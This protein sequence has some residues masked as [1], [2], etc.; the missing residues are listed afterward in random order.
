MITID[1][2]HNLALLVA[3]SVVSGSVGQRWEGR[4]RVAVLQGAVFGGAAVV[5]MLEPYVLAPGVQFDA[6]SVAISISGLYFGPVAALVAGGM[7]GVCR[8][9]LGGA[10]AG[11]G[12]LVIAA[13][14]LPAVIAHYRW[15]AL[16]GN[17]SAARLLGLGVVTHA[18]MLLLM[19]SLPGGLVWEVLPNIGVPVIVLYPLATVFIG[20][21]LS[22][23]C[24]RRDSVRQLRENKERFRA[25]LYSIGDGVI[26]TD[27]QGRVREMNPVAERLS[28]WSED[29]ARGRPLE[30]A[31]RLVNEDSRAAV[32]NPVRRVL[33]GGQCVGLANHT[34]LVARDGTERPIADSGAPIYAEDGK[35]CGAVL[36]FRD[37]SEE[38]ETERALRG[39]R[40]RFERALAHIPD[41]IVIYDL[42]LRIQYINEATRNITGQPAS[43]FLGRRD[44]DVWSPAICD[45]FVP[46]LRAAL[47][48]RTVHTVETDLDLPGV[49][50][51]SLFITCVPVL[52]AAGEVLEILGITRDLTERKRSEAAL[53]ESE[54]LLRIAGEVAHIGGWAVD[55]PEGRLTWSDEVRAIH[56]EPPGFVPALAEAFEYFPPKWR[57]PLSRAFSACREA[58][59]PYDMELE[60]ITAGGRRLWARSIGQ[61]VRDNTGAIVRVQGA[62]QDITDIKQFESSL[63]QSQARFR[64]LADAMPLVV[65]TASPDGNVDYSSQTLARYTGR[66]GD[67]ASNER[68][69]EVLHPEDIERTMDVWTQAVQRGAHYVN[70]FRIL[71]RD[72]SYRWNHVEATPIRDEVGAIVKWY[73][74]ATDIHDTK[75]NEEAMTRMARRLTTTLESITD[76]FCILDNE[77]RYTYVNPEAERLARRPREELLGKRYSDFY[78]EIR[79]SELEKNLQCALREKRAISFEFYYEPFDLWLELHAYP[80]EEGLAISYRDITERVRSEHALRDVTRRLQGI[81][82]FSPLLIAELDLH[83]RYLV[84][85]RVHRELMGVEVEGKTLQ[86]LLPPAEA[87]LYLREI[88]AVVESR[89]ARSVEVIIEFRGAPHCFDTVLFPLTDG[90]GAVTSVGGIAIDVTDRKNA[91]DERERLESQLR[92]SQKMEAVGRLAGGVAHDFN[93]MLGVILGYTEMALTRLENDDELRSDLLQV[94]QAANRSADLTRQLLAFARKQTIA[95]KVLDLN[96]TVASILKMLRRL[97]GED[98]GLLWKPGGNLWPVCIDPTQVDQIL[99]NLTVNA[100]DAIRGVGKVTIETDCVAFDEAYCE[101]HPGFIPGEYV[102][103]AVSDDGC[104]MDEE[105]RTHVFEPFFT[106]KPQGQG[107]GLG[108]ATVYGIVK[109]NEGFIYVYS[110]PGRGTA[111]RVY[112]PRFEAPP[113]FRQVKRENARVPTGTETVLLVEDETALLMLGARQL[114][115]LGYTVLAAASPTEALRIAGTFDGEIDLL[116]TDVIMP[117]M[118]GRELWRQLDVLRPGIKTLFMSGYSADVIAHHGALDTGVHF[119]QKPFKVGS[120]AA[121]VR[122]ALGDTAAQ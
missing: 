35:T 107:T 116:I 39:G 18:I 8:I 85:N 97:I 28:G 109:Q 76:A 83:G 86:D 100:R 58:G 99:A 5:S 91:A 52:D 43:F 4:R 1:L 31:F 55:F 117:E 48:T 45:L 15:R 47:E 29:E 59:T 74:T 14:A 119:L 113:G 24:A 89:A 30:E 62:F 51:R 108:L 50:V 16:R 82:D 27:A 105:T 23:Q 81:L 84:A 90:Q 13:S 61:A 22:G 122:E 66:P 34:L 21:I 33:Q 10:G 78:P 41:V 120:M 42:D 75:Q 32:E 2:I 96:D 111:I 93:N 63:A 73:G 115:R 37:R 87:A 3:L 110:E 79:G 40:E 38:R 20:T 69:L 121:K 6:R 12:L 57:G 11:T 95:P 56:E 72:G 53:R 71:S 94:Q 26:T 25:T 106:T 54:A 88:A 77:F 98:V 70:E 9:L 104:G 64:Q 102:L 114:E 17:F 118:D 36:V 60:I 19:F 67:Y 65:W 46:A 92:Q 49:G 103:L 68:W 101:Q 112:L 7:A 80:S 44:E